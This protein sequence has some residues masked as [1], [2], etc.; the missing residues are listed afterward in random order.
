MLHSGRIFR[1][2][3][4]DNAKDTHTKVAVLLWDMAKQAVTKPLLGLVRLARLKIIEHMTC[5]HIVLVLGVKHGSRAS[6]PYTG[7]RERG[8]QPF[9][10]YY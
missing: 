4:K 5:T 10:F 9:N 7:T 6:H 2:L 1:C 3:I 8:S